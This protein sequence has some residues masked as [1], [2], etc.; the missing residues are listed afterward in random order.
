MSI[1]SKAINI[2]EYYASKFEVVD[3]PIDHINDDEVLIKVAYVPF[4]NYDLN[5]IK[6]LKKN[7]LPYIPCFELSG[8]IEK[9]SN[10][11]LIGKKVAVTSLFKGTLQSRIVVKTAEVVVLND[12]TDL[13]K[14]SI[15]S[16]NPMTALGIVD[17]AV[18][19]NS[20]AFA[21]TAA[22][23]NCGILINKIAKTKGITVISI[24][25]SQERVEELKLQGFDNIVNSS[26]ETFLE[27]LSFQMTSLEANVIF[28]CLSGP[29]AG[30]LIKALPKK[31]T[32]VNFGT[33][34]SLP[35]SEID[36]TDFRWGYK[37]IT[38]FLVVT[39]I[40]DQIKKGSFD[41][42]KKYIKDN[43]E[44][45]ESEPG[46]VFPVLKIKEGVEYSDKKSEG[47]KV[48]FDLNELS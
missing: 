5:K 15:L 29:I 37:K 7:P 41:E 11:D 13:I 43:Q 4:S 39:W 48:V 18:E 24:V 2:Q 44:M 35:M 3:V 42:H 9:S 21:L 34:T 12:N 16:C 10:P 33:E 23:S 40:E 30:K 1:I 8:I 20:K 38:S 17:T 47:F 32:Y 27:D 22:N 26:S 45:F 14:A 25:R 6:G 31:G 36:A 46:K 28:D 19:L